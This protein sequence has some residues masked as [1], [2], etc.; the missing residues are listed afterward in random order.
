[1]WVSTMTIKNW[2]K[3]SFFVLIIVGVTTLFI[4]RNDTARAGLESYIKSNEA[5]TSRI[6]EVQDIIIHNFSYVA[7]TEH[8]TAYR[9]YHGKITGSN[10]ELKVS[11]KAVKSEKELTSWKYNIE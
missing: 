1:M 2:I 11:V 6:G 4:E 5:I 7:A 8:E 10:G 3:Y 9:I